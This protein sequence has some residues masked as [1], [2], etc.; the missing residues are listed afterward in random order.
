MVFH[1]RQQDGIPGLQVTVSE[2]TGDQVDGFGRTPGEN[3]L[4]RAACAEKTRHPLPGLLIRLG[5]ALGKG[6]HATVN[7]RVFSRYTSAL[8]FTS[9][10]RMGKSARICAISPVENA[11]GVAI[12]LQ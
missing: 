1:F 11:F 10:L 12:L 8:P 7:I 4:G 3:D 2:T 9:R 6:V 5:G